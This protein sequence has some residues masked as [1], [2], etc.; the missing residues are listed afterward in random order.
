MAVSVSRESQKAKQ[1]RAR[2]VFARLRAQ[3]PDAECS[4][5]Y[6][7]P[8]ELL[9]ATILAAQCTDVRVN[10]VTKDLFKKYKTCEDYVAAPALQLEKE[11]QTCGFFRQ[12]TKSIQNTCR[13]IIE[14]FGG[15]VPGT[16]EELTR[17]PGVGRKTANVILGQCFKVPSI[18]VD[19]HCLRVT[20]RLGFTRNDDPTKV[21]QDLMKVWDKEKWTLFSHL[22]VFHGR[23]ICSARGPKCS[24][25]PVNTLCPFPHTPEGKKAAK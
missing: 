6:R 16:M 25:C 8:L 22:M 20:N 10:I 5:D 24:Q 2:E 19:T 12:K 4:L 17:L 7:N 14:D 23:A 18:I 15:K 21:E 3:Y 9:V 11:I 1:A 13:A